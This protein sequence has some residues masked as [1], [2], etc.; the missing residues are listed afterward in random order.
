VTKVNPALIQMIT[1][2]NAEKLYEVGQKAVD[3]LKDADLVI[4]LTHLGVDHESVSNGTSSLNLLEHLEGADLLLDGHAHFVMTTGQHGEPI[5]STGTKF[6]Y[7]GAVVIDNESK[8][9]EDRFLIP[10]YVKN[11]LYELNAADPDVKAVSDRI[12]ADVDAVYN[13]VFASSE[14]LLNGER[15]P[16][17]RTEETNLGDLITDAMVWSVVK[18]GGFEQDE[19]HAVVGI[20]N[21]GGIRA[22][23]EAGD[24]TRKDITR[25]L[26]FGNTVAVAYV[27]GAELREVL[28]ASTFCTPKAVG[29][30]PQTSGIEWTLDTTKAYDEGP[31]YVLN[32]KEGTYHS[33]ASI[34]RVSIQKINGEDFNPKG[35]YAVVTNDFC[36]VG[37]DTYNVLGRSNEFFDTGVPVDEA[38]MQYVEQVLE[39]KITQETYGAPQGR[40]TIK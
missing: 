31:L 21:G 40:M 36:V 13:E 35:V 30:F 4:G 20:T 33:P 24:V 9:I 23:I 22:T 7:V 2:S 18:E 29:G 10:T 5:Q 12:M 25:T 34:Q 15:D 8:A 17:N 27:T 11:D 3:E 28:E 14:V 16:G 38:V 39:G 6:E 37:G 26:P 32:G 19:I 1:F